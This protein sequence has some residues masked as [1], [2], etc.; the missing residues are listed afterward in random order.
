MQSSDWGEVTHDSLEDC[1]IWDQNCHAVASFW[2][3]PLVFTL[4]SLWKE[5][6]LLSNTFIFSPVVVLRKEALNTGVF[7]VLWNVNGHYGTRFLWFLDNSCLWQICQTNTSEQ[8]LL[9]C[10]FSPA[11]AHIH[12]WVTW[13]WDSWKYNFSLK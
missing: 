1:S 7:P 13:S 5:P 12:F 3:V 4:H 8:W 10:I 6:N 11:N 2:L 9:S